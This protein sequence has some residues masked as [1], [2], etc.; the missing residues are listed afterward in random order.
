MILVKTVS[1]SQIMFNVKEPYNVES[2]E[3][4]LADGTLC[5]IKSHFLLL[6]AILLILAIIF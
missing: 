5:Q 1:K 4:G 3:K 2:R 6:P